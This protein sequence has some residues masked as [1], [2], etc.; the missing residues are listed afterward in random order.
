MYKCIL[1][2]DNGNKTLELEMLEQKVAKRAVY[3]SAPE[4]LLTGKFLLT[5]REKRGTKTKKERG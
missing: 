5:Y 1:C 4:R 3:Q 2:I